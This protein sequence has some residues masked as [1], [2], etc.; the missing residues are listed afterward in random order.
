M[1][2]KWDGNLSDILGILQTD[3]NHDVQKVWVHIDYGEV[4][5]TF[6]LCDP[7]NIQLYE[8]LP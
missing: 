8:N 2:Q 5:I 6:Y 3:K 4:I 1:Y 7:S